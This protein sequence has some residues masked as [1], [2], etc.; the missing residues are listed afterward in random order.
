MPASIHLSMQTYQPILP[1]FRNRWAVALQTAAMLCMLLQ[2]LAVNSY[3]THSPTTGAKEWAED[4]QAG[5]SWWDE[6]SDGDQMTNAEEA[7]FGSDP[8]RIDS[9]FDGLTDR[10]ERDLTPA[11]LN[12]I[13]STDP[14]LWDSDSDGY[15]DYDE[16]YNW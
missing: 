16:F 10:D 1:R 15:S 2:P 11:M 5:H 12:G 6:D 3:W 14:W 13:G 7:V 4:P 8:Y 9:D